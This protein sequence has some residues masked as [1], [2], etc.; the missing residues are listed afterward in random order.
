MAKAL[1]E[2]VMKVAPITGFSVKIVERK[3]TTLRSTLT[4]Q[5]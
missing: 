5:I 1:R 2:V 3:G 4:P